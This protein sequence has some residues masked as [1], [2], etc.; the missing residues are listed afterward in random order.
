MR[1][2][3][4]YWQDQPG[5]CPRI[6]AFQSKSKIHHIPIKTRALLQPSRVVALCRFPRLLFRTASHANEYNKHVFSLTRRKSSR[7]PC[8]SSR[9]I[10]FRTESLPKVLVKVPGAFRKTRRRAILRPPPKLLSAG[11]RGVRSVLCVRFRI[12][13]SHKPS[14]LAPVVPHAVISKYGRPGLLCICE[15]IRAMIPI[16]GSSGPSPLSAATGPDPP[17]G[18]VAHRQYSAH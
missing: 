16:R 9:Q 15:Q 7:P 11:L 13:Y 3:Y 1:Q 4:D 2:A 18:A 10:T 14:L 12:A 6:S 5:S 17:D 8:G